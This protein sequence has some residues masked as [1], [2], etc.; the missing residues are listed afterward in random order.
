MTAGGNPSQ[1]SWASILLRACKTERFTS[2]HAFEFSC[3]R[4]A[5]DVL[6]HAFESFKTSV[7]QLDS[8]MGT[9]C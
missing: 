7:N 8:L 9:G 4:Q 1:R 6:M 5:H 3:I 2:M